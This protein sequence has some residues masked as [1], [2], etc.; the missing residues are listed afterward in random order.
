LRAPESIDLERHRSSEVDLTEVRW[1]HVAR[2]CVLDGVVKKKWIGCAE[3]LPSKAVRAAC[4]SESRSCFA[5]KTCR[6][7]FPISIEIN[8]LL[9]RPDEVFTSAVSHKERESL[10]TSKFIGPD[11]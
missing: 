4:S 11:K 5:C 7:P 8:D 9:I 2:P 1:T 6:Y 3:E 10:S